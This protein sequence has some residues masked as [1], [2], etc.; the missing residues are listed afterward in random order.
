MRGLAARVASEGMQGVPGIAIRR[1]S[2]E[3]FIAADPDIARQLAAGIPGARYQEIPECGH[4]PQ[5]QKPDALVGHAIA[6]AA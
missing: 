1:M 3:G 4:C 5:V 2:P 6:F